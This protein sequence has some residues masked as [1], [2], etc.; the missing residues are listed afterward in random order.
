GEAGLFDVPESGPGP[1]K[2]DVQLRR[3]LAIEGTVRD[4]SDEPI[5]GVQVRVF[6]NF[7]G[8]EGY[9][10]AASYVW[11]EAPLSHTDENGRFLL[12]GATP[13]KLWLQAW[14]PDYG[15][16][17]ARVEGVEGQ[18]LQGVV[19][20]FAGASISGVFLDENG[21]P[22][23]GANVNAQGPVNS[24]NQGW[25]HAPTDG[26]G[27]FRFRGLKEG[28]YNLS[29]W[30]TYGTPQ[31]QNAIPT[32]SEGVI[33]RLQASQSLC[34]E[35]M[36]LLTSRALERFRLRIYPRQDGSG[37]EMGVT[38]WDGELRSPEGRFERP[39]SPGRYVVAV[40]AAGHAP[41]FERDVIVEA[42]VP[43]AP[44]L[45][46]LDGGASVRGTVFDAAGKPV[47]GQRVQCRPQRAPGQTHSREDGMMSGQDTTDDKGRYIIE[48]LATGTYVVQARM[49]GRSG[50]GTGQA[51]VVVRGMET[52][53]RD[54]HI[55]PTGK[56]LVRVID[57]E[58][59]PIAGVFCQFQDADGSWIGG[60]N[61]TD[62]QGVATSQP[63]RMGPATLHTYHG[64][65]EC[66]PMPVA[67]EADKTLPVNVVM[68][69]KETPPR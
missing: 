15:T 18:R 62:D 26:L 23:H 36:S 49:R 22:I 10:W 3:G 27:R 64:T 6:P 32:G 16:S 57:E 21:E 9:Q 11:Q 20:S 50:G 66:D 12:E 58:D 25:W 59:R 34:G 38:S 55:L 51:L 46:Q 68:R 42:N 53:D 39:I 65:Y 44:L 4:T 69:K 43:P 35:A 28:S 61:A 1:E 41:R 17:G 2:V 31:P 33:F 24:Q 63:L 14:A 67:V 7:T 40:S 47:P 8:N 56:L 5:A 60:A 19:I 30:S 54:V 37:K 48:G 45:F 13:G 52:A 29:A